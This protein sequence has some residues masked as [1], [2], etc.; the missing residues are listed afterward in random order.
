MSLNEMVVGQI[1]SA[2]IAYVR[3]VGPYGPSN[4]EAM[5]KL[6]QWADRNQLLDAQATLLGIPQD[7][8]SS[9][10]P[11]HCRY[12]ACIVLDHDYHFKNEN[13]PAIHIG[14]FAGGR[15]LICI[16][17]HTA[18]GIRDAWNEIIL[19]VHAKEIQMD[20]K[21]MI[22]RISCTSAGSASM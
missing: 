4:R 1:A 7:D 18:E 5:E 9:T 8:P 16:V 3:Q 13:A 15:Y 12:D 19:H 14:T 20:R 6:K 17:P 11:Q 10:P 2:T 22:E 21:P